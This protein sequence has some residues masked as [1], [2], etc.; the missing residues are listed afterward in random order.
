MHQGD[1]RPLTELKLPWEWRVLGALA[2]VILLYLYLRPIFTL[3]LLFA[4]GL[5]LAA[6]LHPTV[7]WLDERVHLPR[8]VPALLVV[9]MVL[10]TLTALLL[11]GVPAL[12][13]QAI[14][15]IEA[16]PGLYARARGMVLAFS[17]RNPAWAG[18]I[19]RQLEAV[20]LQR[21]AENIVGW[22][23]ASGLALLGA[24]GAMVIILVIALYTL[25]YPLPLVSG[26]LALWPESEHARVGKS[27]NAALQ[28]VR[29]WLGAQFIAML[30]VGVLSTLALWI[31]DVPYAL[32]FG[33]LAGLLEVVP[34]LGPV[35]SALPPMAV[36]FALDPILAVWV[37]IAFT[38]VQQV[39]NHLVVPLVFGG[40]LRVH[41]VPILFAVLTMGA[42]FGVLGALLAV[43]LVAVTQAILQEF[44]QPRAVESE[45]LSREA[46]EALHME[47][48]EARNSRSRQ[49]RPSP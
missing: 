20:E 34:N 9:V 21:Y 48:P 4:A 47:S 19:Q 18:Y 10:G 1:E 24:A 3:G 43:P 11:W 45:R 26:L 32:L 22:V 28:K 31:L 41:P 38:V 30:T 39:E 42:L 15:L 25:V 5:L 37:A 16:L 17:E 12:L 35:V 40:A 14:E 33:V 49:A 44:R 29:A 7:T 27:I 13:N 46:R 8:A 2:V 23:G 36:A 6:A